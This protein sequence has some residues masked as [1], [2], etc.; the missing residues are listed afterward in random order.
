MKIIYSKDFQEK[1]KHILQY[2]AQ[3]KPSSSIKFYNDLKNSIE[4]LPLFP[5]QYRKSHYFNDE[6]IRD[7]VF[8]RY[9]IIYEIHQ[10]TIEILS[11]FNQNKP[12][13]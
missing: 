1:L 5:Y 11:I 9:T 8:K 7:M 13:N 3:D 12:L 6:N 10:N 4:K 2:I